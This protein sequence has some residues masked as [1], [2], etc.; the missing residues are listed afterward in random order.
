[1][2]LIMHVILWSTSIN[3]LHEWEEGI[4]EQPPTA[5]KDPTLCYPLHNSQWQNHQGTAL[6][7]FGSIMKSI[8]ECGVDDPN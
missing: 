1:M 7:Q 2:P 4:T 6:P 8:V 3:T 5:S